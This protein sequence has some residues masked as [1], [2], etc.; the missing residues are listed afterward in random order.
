MNKV[1]LIKFKNF[2]VG[3]GL[4]T[5]VFTDESN[6]ITVET[7]TLD[8]YCTETNKKP[9]FLKIDAENTELYVLEGATHVLRTYHPI[10]V[11]EG[12]EDAIKTARG[13]AVLL[14]VVKEVMKN[15]IAALQKIRV[16]LGG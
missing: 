10:V 3:A 4:N 8:T 11:I 15:A 9:T 14:D 2:G 7:T 12:N 16:S 5:A 1:G 6:T 13:S